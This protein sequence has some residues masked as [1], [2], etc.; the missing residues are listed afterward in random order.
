LPYHNRKTRLK[1][2]E[3][4][5]GEGAMHPNV[6]VVSHP[7]LQHSLTILRN[8]TSDTAAF[9]R[10][11]A[12]T[13]S[14]LLVEATRNLH[15]KAVDI[16]TPL[17]TA[18]GHELEERLVIVPVL[19]AG[20][21][22]LPAAQTLLP[23]VPVGFL[24]LERDEETAVAHEYY[25]KFPNGLSGYKAI[26]LDPM[27]ATGGSLEETIHAVIKRGCSCI[28]LVCVVAAPEGIERV[29]KSYPQAQLYTA[30][31]DS[32]LDARKFIVPGL[33]DFGDRYFG[34]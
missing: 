18:T 4:E 26:I 14:F 21:A 28:V 25:S 8:D 30:A 2:H 5:V 1:S 29:M 11:A 24:G 13:A 31:I 10:H 7:L 17:E 33:G 23:D 15:T 19:R 16:T 6:T 20:L 27:L 3:N 34:T 12:I 32:H 22:L 9:R